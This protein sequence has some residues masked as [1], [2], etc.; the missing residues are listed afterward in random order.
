VPEITLGEDAYFY[1]EIGSGPV[2]AHFIHCS[3]AS[4]KSWLPLAETFSA[5]ARMTAIDLPGHGRSAPTVQADDL[6]GRATAASVALLE[7][8]GEP[9]NLVGHS[10]GATVALRIAVERPDLVKSLVLFEP[11]LFSVLIGQQQAAYDQEVRDNTAFVGFL[12]NGNPMAAAADFL[13]RWGLPGEWQRMPQDRREKMA[14]AIGF[15]RLTSPVLHGLACGTLHLDRLRDISAPT[16]VV[17]GDQSPDVMRVIAEVLTKAIPGS[18]QIAVKGAGH[19]VPL[20]HVAESSAIMRDF[21]T[22]AGGVS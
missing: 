6:H 12:E 3:L 9:V 20:T 21:W 18:S 15:V 14:L 8:A 10:F 16:V 2:P 13:N 17:S 11:V 19:M 1:R 7:Q 5:E 22:A 4:G